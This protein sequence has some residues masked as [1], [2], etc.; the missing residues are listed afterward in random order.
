M[1]AVVEE[2]AF[3]GVAA[4]VSTARPPAVCS[5]PT[6][7]SPPM[8]R[9]VAHDSMPGAIWNF[10]TT[11]AMCIPVGSAPKKAAAAGLVRMTDPLASHTNTPSV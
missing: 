2:A 11:S 7:V 6:T 10:S 1:A 9:Q 5:A 3:T 4:E 8:A